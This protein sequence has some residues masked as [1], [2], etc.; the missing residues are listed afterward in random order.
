MRNPDVYAGLLF[1][2]LG[3]AALVLGRSYPM[4][5]L[6]RMGPGFFPTVLAVCLVS[7]G[8]LTLLRPLWQR[9][10]KL[11]FSLRPFVALGAVVV[12]GFTV[13]HLGLVPATILLVG[14]SYLA[15]SSS[16]LRETI[17]LAAGLT[18]LA[19]AITRGL[20]LPVPLFLP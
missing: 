11:T 13:P 3:A 6:A 15:D 20:G 4:G 10:D 17:V 19:I 7:L 14:T 8:F 5:T 18:L 2:G 9:G 1:I 16:R 12:F